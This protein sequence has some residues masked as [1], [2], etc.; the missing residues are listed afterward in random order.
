MGHSN[1][2]RLYRVDVTTGNVTLITEGLPPFPDG[3]AIKGRTVYSLHPLSAFLGVPDEV[4]MIHLSSDLAIGEIVGTITSPN[5]DGVASG[6]VF[7]SSLYVNNAR[8]STFPQPDTEY[9]V[10]KL[11]TRIKGR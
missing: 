5:L 6:A 3:L 11:S 7:G 4:K 2:S 1:L 8:Y 10:T 9:W